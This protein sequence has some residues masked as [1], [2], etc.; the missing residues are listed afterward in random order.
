[1]RDRRSKEFFLE[2]VSAVRWGEARQPTTNGYVYTSPPPEGVGFMPPKDSVGINGR[3]FQ[4]GRPPFPAGS[5]FLTIH[6]LNQGPDCLPD[7]RSFGVSEGQ[8]TGTL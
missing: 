7:A 3:K 6:L 2:I 1:M 4:D 8:P 5:N